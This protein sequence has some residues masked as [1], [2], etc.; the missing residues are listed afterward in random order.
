VRTTC[1]LP[2]NLN[3]NYHNLFYCFYNVINIPYFSA[4]KTHFFHLKICLKNGVRPI[5]RCVLYAKK[6][7]IFL[8]GINS[9]VRLHAIKSASSSEDDDFCGFEDED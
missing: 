7:G 8:E 4:Y 2:Q 9:A 1:V 5:H 3:H 6:Y